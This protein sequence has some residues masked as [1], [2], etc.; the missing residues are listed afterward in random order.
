MNS[1]FQHAVPV[2]FVASV[3]LLGGCASGKAPEAQM[4]RTTAALT[5]AQSAGA[6]EF[7]PVE[8]K[9]AQD[10]FDRA[11]AEAER[12]HY[13]AAHNLAELAEADAKLAETRARSAKAQKAAST[14]QDGIRV[15]REEMNRA[16]QPA[17]TTTPAQ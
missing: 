2:A 17:G 13:D 3:A 5:D 7:A 6:A 14:L 10:K 12:K 15:L 11:R 4:A 9:A 1:V 8:L 16:L